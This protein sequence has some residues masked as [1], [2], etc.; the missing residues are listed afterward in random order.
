LAAIK[1]SLSS[2]AR[3]D[4]KDIQDYIGGEKES[5][6]TALRVIEKIIDRMEDLLNQPNSGTLL[7][8]K[9]NFPTNYRYVK[10]KGYLIFYRYENNKIFVDR[11]IYGKRDFISILFPNTENEID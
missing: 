7:S 4:L 6:Q 2:D 1:I 9:V 8:P 3:H 11:I 5:P 10:S